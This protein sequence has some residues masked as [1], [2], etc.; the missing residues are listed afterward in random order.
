[1]SYAYISDVKQD[2]KKNLTVKDLS[3]IVMTIPMQLGVEA[4]MVTTIQLKALFL[5]RELLGAN[6]DLVKGV[7]INLFK[8]I[9]LFRKTGLGEAISN[10]INLKR[11]RVFPGKT[12]NTQLRH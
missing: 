3:I 12:I 4:V 1:M 5:L 7:S 9:F 2:V 11:H 8:N 6:T 10:S